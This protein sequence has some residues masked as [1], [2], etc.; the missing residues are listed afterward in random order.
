LAGK[1]KELDMV[2]VDQNKLKVFH[3]IVKD[4]DRT[5]NPF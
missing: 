3:I 1:I 2:E 5:S 4:I